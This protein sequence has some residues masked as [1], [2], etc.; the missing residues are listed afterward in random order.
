MKRAGLSLQSRFQI[1]ILSG[2]ALVLLLMALLWF[3]EQR[4]QEE[5]IEIARQSTHTLLA[6]Q[7]RLNGEAQ[8]RQ[9]ADAL[10][11]PLYYFDLDAIGILTRNALRAPE[12]DY[13]LV[14]DPKTL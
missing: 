9:L 11:N 6:E 10:A 13:V 4:S 12:V 7:M 8:T 3:R 1:A 2:L 14:Y 5:A